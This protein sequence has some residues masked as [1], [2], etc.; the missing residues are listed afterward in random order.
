MEVIGEKVSSLLDFVDEKIGGK[1][2]TAFYRVFS[3]Q[4]EP[5]KDIKNEP[6][7]FQ[8]HNLRFIVEPKERHAQDLLYQWVRRST[9]FDIDHCQI[10]AVLGLLTCSHHWTLA[11]NTSCYHLESE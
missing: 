10:L 7:K 1:S 4:N 2:V 5:I 3:C 9:M 8:H 6:M 11:E